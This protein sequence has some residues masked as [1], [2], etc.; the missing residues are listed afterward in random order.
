MYDNDGHIFADLSTILHVESE[1]T[2]E[3]PDDEYT[4][5]K[6]VTTQHWG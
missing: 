6:K 2:S 3:S 5:G 4:T 1:Q